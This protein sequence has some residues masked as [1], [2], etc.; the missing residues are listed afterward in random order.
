MLVKGVGSRTI[1]ALSP[2][3]Q[4]KAKAEKIFTTEGTEKGKN[5]KL[6][7]RDPPNETAGRRR[8]RRGGTNGKTGSRRNL[9]YNPRRNRV[10]T[11]RFRFPHREVNSHDSLVICFGRA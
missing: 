6:H 7:R 8:G 3:A 5:P 9:A 1:V 11:G 4:R 2:R 10:H